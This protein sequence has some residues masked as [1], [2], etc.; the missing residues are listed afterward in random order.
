MVPSP[1]FDF[2]KSLLP[3]GCRYLLGLDEVGRG[4]LAGPVTVGAFLLDLSVFDPQTFINL[5]VRDS[6]L[7]TPSKRQTIN[8]HLQSHHHSLFFAPSQEIDNQGIAVVLKSLFTTA[9]KFYSSYSPFCLIDG[10]YKF[11]FPNARPIINGDQKCFS[12]A[13]ASICAKVHR[14]KLMENYHQKYPD[15]D[16]LHNKGYGTAKHLSALKTHGPCP[17]HRRSFIHFL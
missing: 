6:K 12:I 14:D 9:L 5:G 7:L 15:Y 8:H 11:N 4:P 1:D 10:N 2:E 3:S 16:F 17:L 13:A